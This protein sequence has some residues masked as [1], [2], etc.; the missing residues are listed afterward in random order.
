MQLEYWQTINS[1][2]DSNGG[3]IKPPPGEGWELQQALEGYHHR[4]GNA[5]TVF[6]WKRI[7]Q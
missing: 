4:E 7:K 3:P 6:V 1:D 2:E 5:Y